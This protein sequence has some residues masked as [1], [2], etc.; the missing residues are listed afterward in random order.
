MRRLQLH[1]VI[2]ALVTPFTANGDVDESSMR[3]IVRFQLD[4]GIHGF[5]P[6][7]T[8]GLGPAMEPAKRMKAAEIVVSET[9]GRIPVIIQVGASDPMIS[10]ELAVHAQRIG[11]SAIASV[12]PFYY[13]PDNLAI[14]EYYTRLTKATKLPTLVYNIPRHTGN[15]I[16]PELLSA[17]SKI[18]GIVGIKD[19]SRD[20]TQ[21]LDYINAVPPEF[22]VISGT[23]SFIF[24]ALCAGMQAG[25]SAIANPFPDLLVHLYE[26][27]QK[28][29]FDA[30][31]L[32][33]LRINALRSTLSKPP[34]APLLETLRM[35]GLTSGD[36]KLPLRS[37]TNAEIQDLHEALHKI[38]P[39]VNLDMRRN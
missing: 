35:R 5:F 18:P 16:S 2:T 1:G 28:R 25:V 33:Q 13:N 38:V 20:F 23:D 9:A 11:A 30:A 26:H 21:L 17:L 14:V 19:S 29:D 32:L 12:T 24:S 39:E 22:M 10:I 3:E 6:M 8:N 4:S 31:K 15:N 7:G 34:I 37:M 27:Y 36:V